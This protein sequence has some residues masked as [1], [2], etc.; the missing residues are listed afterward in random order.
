VAN[1]NSRCFQFCTKFS[2]KFACFSSSRFL[3]ALLSWALC[4][5][6]AGLVA[7]GCGPGSGSGSGPA[8]KLKVTAPTSASAGSPF[9]VVVTALDANGNIVTSYSGKVHFTSSDTAA[10][11]PPDYTFL[12]SDNGVHTFTNQATLK[13]VGNQTITATDATTSSI[14][15]AS[16]MIAVSAATTV[17]T[18]FL[19]TA[20]MTVNA[21]VPFSVS[22]TAADVNGNPVTTYAGTVHFTS[23]DTAAMLPADFTFTP[24][25]QGTQTFTNAFTLITQ[26]SQSITATD[27]GTSSIRGSASLSVQGPVLMTINVTPNPASVPFGGSQQFTATGTY[28]DGSSQNLTQQATWSSS[29][30]T[31]A[32][33]SNA[34]GSQ[35]LATAG[36][37]AGTT[38]ITATMGMGANP[39]T[40]QS[41][42]N[43][44]QGYASNA[45]RYLLD[46]SVQNISVDAIVPSTGQLR[47]VGL[48]PITNSL[49]YPQSLV[50][51]PGGA[52]YYLVSAV[53]AAGGLEIDAYF[54]GA[55]GQLVYGS[56]VNGNTYGG[57]PVVDP[58]QRF[59]YVED[60]NQTIVVYQIGAFGSL[61]SSAPAASGVTQQGP[62][63]IDSTGSYLYAQTGSSTITSYQINSTNGVLTQVGTASGPASVEHLVVA[64]SGTVVYALSAS[65]ASIFAYS[66]K[67]GNLTPLTNSPFAV[68]IGGVPEQMAIDP[69]SSY[70]YVTEGSTD[71]LYGF[72]IGSQGDLTEM[73]SGTSF[74]VGQGPGPINV[75]AAGSF[76][77]VNNRAGDIWVYS[78]ASGTGLLSPVSQMRTQGHQSQ[79]I[80]TGASGLTFTPTAL[81]VAIEGGS[82]DQFS[83]D[84]ST[85]NLVP[86][87]T[88][89]LGAPN[90]AAT[91]VTDPFDSYAYVPGGQ[92]YSF[93]IASTG[94][95]PIGTA[96]AGKGASWAATDMS[97]SYLFATMHTDNTIWGYTLTNGVASGGAT[98]TTNPGPN[99]I[100][101]E[102]TGQSFYVAEG[103]DNAGNIDVFAYAASQTNLTLRGSIP[104]GVSQNSIAVDPSGR[105]AYSADP[106]S[107]ALWEFKVAAAGAMLSLN[108]TQAIFVGT[109]ASTPGPNS[110]VVEPSGKFVYAPNQALGQ[111][112][113]FS[114][115]PT[116]GLL[117]PLAS[118]AALG[119]TGTDPVQLGVDISGQ[120]LYCVNQGSNDISIFSIDLSTGALTSVGT[121]QA[122]GTQPNG[123][124]LVGT[125]K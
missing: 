17:A 19:L 97:G 94:L 34:A 109:P 115:D 33:I 90:G 122:G 124:A 125:R 108:S 68:P 86:M 75:D 8:A 102:P 1:T 77:Y 42:L 11:L 2:S 64:P 32:T 98:A 83:I 44:Y 96:G 79:V 70:L 92:L 37:A 95:T 62:M 38:F 99:F 3:A 100:T 66:V 118:G 5:G 110:V 31:V 103:S 40:G 29:N 45:S 63:A 59:F 50:G 111:I 67:N 113:G 78:L 48:T 85:G 47:A 35:G 123:F 14:T 71:G 58:L 26:A 15:G 30:M 60:S 6:I 84:S 56:S 9:T 120:F 36:N 53:S 41:S 65:P 93:S 81:Y 105:F 51:V 69:S 39:V 4:A 106:G 57:T 24:A 10:V 121:V 82:V 117:T 89:S 87:S 22:V 107:N 52:L 7:F 112:F 91:V 80:N 74:A 27:T 76:V 46:L 72:T 21:G 116:T 13:T 23:S 20:P 43:A 114:I 12:A 73:Q 61:N 28:S 54:L 16:G 119:S 55:N 49:I 18:Q 101:S 104:G 88:P 25:N